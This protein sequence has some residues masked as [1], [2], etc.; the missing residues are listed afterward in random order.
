MIQSPS[1][2]RSVADEERHLQLQHTNPQRRS[3]QH[4]TCR[5]LFKYKPYSQSR[6]YDNEKRPMLA[7]WIAVTF[8]SSLTHRKDCMLSR[9]LQETK[10]FGFRI[11]CSGPLLQGAI[12]AAMSMTRG[13]G[14]FSL[15]PALTFNYVVRSGTGPF[16]L[17]E[18]PFEYRWKSA[19]NICAALDF[20][21]QE[22]IR[23]YQEGNASPGDVDENGN[24][25]MH[26]SLWCINFCSRRTIL[27]FYQRACTNL[28]MLYGHPTEISDMSEIYIQFI[29][30][31]YNNFGVPLNS[32]NAR[33]LYGTWM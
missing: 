21:R 33:G 12:Q 20:Q 24:T 19:A 31:L 4:C 27:K 18:N 8:S 26:V 29:R 22:L 9:E 25:V 6:S 14:G 7:R 30:D 16:K 3:L 17:F 13:S 23:L 2:L 15:S 1:L 10:Q 11:S 5:A 32:T 28:A